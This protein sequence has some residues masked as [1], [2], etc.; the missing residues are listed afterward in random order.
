M[1]I[2]CKAGGHSKKV[3]LSSN[4]GAFEWDFPGHRW[5][6]FTLASARLIQEWRSRCG[7]AL[8]SG[9]LSGF[10]G[11]R[12]M[13]THTLLHTKRRRLAPSGV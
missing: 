8:S 1:G 6:E 13:H 2:E 10:G 12:C 5:M 9:G 4:S 7:V 11:W 3:I